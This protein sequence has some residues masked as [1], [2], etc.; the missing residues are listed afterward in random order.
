M[1]IQELMNRAYATALA[2]GFYDPPKTPLEAHALIMAEVGE[3]VEAA[4][5]EMPPIHVWPDGKPDGECVELADAVIRIADYCRS[6]GW[7]LE[8]ALEL[9]LQFN[10]TRPYKHGKKI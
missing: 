2:K 3:A 6:R 4:R 10:T 5:T 9:K 8:K 7:D 1:T